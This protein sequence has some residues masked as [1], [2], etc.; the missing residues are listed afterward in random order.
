M[1]PPSLY[2]FATVPFSLG[3]A[4]SCVTELALVTFHAY[5]VEACRHRTA[6]PFGSAEPWL[7]RH[8]ELHRRT[9][10]LRGAQ[11]DR[12]DAGQPVP[13]VRLR[14]LSEPRRSDQSQRLVDSRRA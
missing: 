9:A 10:R 12:Q 4:M 6:D 8:L 14:Q 11:G 1:P 13:S 2:V 3:P 5:G 7:H